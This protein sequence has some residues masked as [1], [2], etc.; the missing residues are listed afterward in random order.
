MKISTIKY[1]NKYLF[2]FQYFMFLFFFLDIVCIFCI[3]AL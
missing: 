1:Y 3:S 2:F